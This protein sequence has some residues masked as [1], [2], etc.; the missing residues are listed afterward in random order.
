MGMKCMV[1]VSTAKSRTA[2]AQY[3]LLWY[4][5]NIIITYLFKVGVFSSSIL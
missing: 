1:L 5:N 4:N 3:M 2:V